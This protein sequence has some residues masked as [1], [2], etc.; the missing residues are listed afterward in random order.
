MS[1]VNHNFNQ[2][3]IETFLELLASE[4]D[5]LFGIAMEGV[6]GMV[7]WGNFFIVE[8]Y[9]NRL[10]SL[11][12]ENFPEEEGML[13]R[14][15]ELLGLFGQI[16]E[17]AREH[18]EYFIAFLQRVLVYLFSPALIGDVIGM[19]CILCLLMVCFRELE[20][21]NPIHLDCL[22]IVSRILEFCQIGK[23]NEAL[24]N[25]G[26]ATILM[27]NAEGRMDN[28]EYF[29]IKQETLENLLEAFH[30]V[31]AADTLASFVMIVFTVAGDT[32]DFVE[33]IM[34]SDEFLKN[35]LLALMKIDHLAIAVSL[36]CG[37]KV[38]PKAGVE[39]FMKF[40][41]MKLLLGD[42]KVLQ[43]QPPDEFDSC[44][45][46]LEGLEALLNQA[47][48]LVD[49]GDTLY[50][51][52]ALQIEAKKGLKIITNIANGEQDEMAAVVA[53][54]INKEHFGE[55]WENYLAKRRG[56]KTKKAR[57]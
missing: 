25:V 49:G 56:L 22:A 44:C 5:S 54:R 55:K 43:F 50:N 31:S 39:C 19:H 57:Q 45:G 41:F 13:V 4:N 2:D 27:L 6:C 34:K 52:I 30:S 12:P 53:K 24:L 10:F 9:G 32:E 8:N 33:M 1:Q 38:C 18:F 16:C 37:C 3:A 29:K 17:E 7:T 14:L 48:T 21:N 42:L 36:L 11:L 23:E 20:P 15:L 35:V 28:L 51:P 26:F 47:E 40:N 46:L